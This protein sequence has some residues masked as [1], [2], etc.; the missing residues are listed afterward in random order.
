[1][2][3]WTGYLTSLCFGLLIY[4]MEGNNNVYVV[5]GVESLKDTIWPDYLLVLKSG[6]SLLIITTFH[7]DFHT[8]FGR[9]EYAFLKLSKCLFM[10]QTITPLWIGC[11]ALSN[12]WYTFKKL[13]EGAFTWGTVIVFGFYLFIYFWALMVHWVNNIFKPIFK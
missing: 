1:M 8:A 13:S 3:L 7:G 10:Q 12:K 9:K 4:N 11:Y 6:C 2:R 5:L